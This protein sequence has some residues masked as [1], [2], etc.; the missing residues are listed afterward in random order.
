MDELPPGFVAPEPAPDP[1]GY[2]GRT[3]RTLPPPVPAAR[4]P[5]PRSA[6]V[7]PHL[8]WVLVVAVVL[9]VGAAAAAFMVTTTRASL[10]RFTGSS[11]DRAG[12]RGVRI[13][14]SR[15]SFDKPEGWVELR[16]GA[17]PAVATAAES[18]GGLAL[19][20]RRGV[21]GL[22]VAAFPAAADPVALGAG[23]GRSRSV[24]HP[25]GPAQEVVTSNAQ[26]P[27]VSRVTLV[28]AG[29][30]TV[31]VAVASPGEIGDDLLADY[32]A[33]VASLRRNGT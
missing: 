18:A 31:M 17:P 23:G 28:E 4:A 16:A 10:S 5:A 12:A 22:V 25:L 11:A 6:K 13:P 32:R 27:G 29:G 3:V 24:S 21:T 7:A 20:Y 19:T 2:F 15:V 9:A 1:Y 30:G 8:G 14:G 33:V 26:M